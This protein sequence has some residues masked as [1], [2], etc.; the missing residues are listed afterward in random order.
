MRIVRV[1]WLV[2]WLV[3]FLVALVWPVRG[4]ADEPRRAGLV[5]QFGD[6]RVETMCLEFGEGEISGVDF[7]IGSGMELV[8]DAGSSMGVTICQIDGEGC[9]FPADAC[10]CQCMGGGECFYWNYYS[11]DPGEAGWAYSALG[12]AMRKVKPG[13]VEAWVWG[14]GHMPP[15]DELSFEAICSPPSP[16]PLSS[17]TTRVATKTPEPP[18]PLPAAATAAPTTL[19]LS[20]Q[21]PTAQLPTALPTI[22]GS[23]PELPPTPASSTGQSLVGYWPFGLAVLGLAGIGAFVWLRRM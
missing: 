10:F 4:F 16:T 11:R 5:V 7:L 19:E 9:A 15:A 2:G 3:V 6:G 12:A 17:P 20:I 22:A 14:D 23:L 21:T 1:V 18:T 8:V 13:S